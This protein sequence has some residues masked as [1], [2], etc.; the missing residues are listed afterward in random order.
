VL[1]H[2]PLCF[3]KIAPIKIISF[4]NALRGFG[5]IVLPTPEELEREKERRRTMH[6]MYMA[7]HQR[8]AGYGEIAQSSR[9]PLSLPGID[10]IRASAEELVTKMIEQGVLENLQGR[11][12]PRCEAGE[13]KQYGFKEDTI[14]G[15]LSTKDGGKATNISR[16]TVCYRCES[17]RERVVVVDSNPAFFK[18]VPGSL[19]PTFHIFILW[20][21]VEGW[22]ETHLVRFTGLNRSTVAA[23][24]GM[25]RKIMAWDAEESQKE[26]SFGGFDNG[27]TVDIEADESEFGHWCE[28]RRTTPG[29]GNTIKVWHWFVMLGVLERGNSAKFWLRP[30]ELHHS[31]HEPRM[32]GLKNHEW[33]SA[34]DEVIRTR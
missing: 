33:A 12:C 4:L 34:C 5:E 17:C 11:P 28:E 19:S 8:A 2:I 26:I 25:A 22:T 9:A 31:R 7:E 14:L 6:K 29:S 21:T 20:A 10:I 23:S 1:H 3:D 16:A 18:S 30:L 15:A 13:Q 24:M 32:P 27:V